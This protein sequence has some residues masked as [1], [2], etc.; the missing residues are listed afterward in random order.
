MIKTLKIT[1]FVAVLAALGCVAMLAMFG[2]R[3]DPDIQKLLASES[4]VEM[5]RKKNTKASSNN[6]QISPLVKQARALALR[7][8]PPPKPRPVVKKPTKRP[9][10]GV[11]KKRPTPKTATVNTKFKLVATC[12]YEDQPEKSMALLDL[13]AKGLK[14]YR[15]GQEV[16]HLVIQQINDRNIVLYKDGAENSVATMP[17]AKKK[18]LLKSDIAKQIDAAKQTDAETQPSAAPAFPTEILEKLMGLAKD[19]ETQTPKLPTARPRSRSRGKTASKTVRKKPPIPKPTPEP[20]SEEE[21][22]ENLENTI[23]NIKRIMS[24]NKDQSQQK[25]NETFN[26]LLKRLEAEKDPEPNE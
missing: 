19:Q 2:L 24:E 23:L 13:P 21:R 4:V 12:K 14:W 11:A 16:N 10:P 1:G 15:Q 20:I 25:A 6:K 5:F 8:N 9:S 7:I 3:A 18:S 22:K 26:R 17:V